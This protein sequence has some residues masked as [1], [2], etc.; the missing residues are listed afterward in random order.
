MTAEAFYRLRGQWAGE[1]EVDFFD[2][3]AA[4]L[5]LWIAY[6]VCSQKL[7]DV[8]LWGARFINMLCSTSAKAGRI[9]PALLL[10]FLQTAGHAA[11]RQYKKQFSKV[12]DIIRTSVL[13]RFEALKQKNAEGIGATVTQ[14]ALLVED[15]YKSGH[16]FPEPEGKQMK[17]KESEL[18]QDV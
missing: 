12:M 4:S 6:L 16:A 18:S 5:R 2:R 9:A 1:S 13:P 7:E 15:F 11:A 8:W 17:Q 10:E 3:M 14:L